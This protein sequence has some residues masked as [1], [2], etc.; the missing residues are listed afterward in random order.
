MNSLRSFLTIGV[1]IGA[2]PNN[3]LDG[4]VIDA[5]PVMAN[6]NWIVSQVNANASSNT[7]V[8]SSS[9]P[10]FVPAGSVGGTGNAITLTPTPAIVAYVAGQRF[11]F[12]ATATNT[13]TTT[14]ATS[15]LTP[16]N[17]RYADGTNL[18]GA[19]MVTGGMYDVQDNGSYYV[20]MN[21]S[22]GGGIVSW[23]PTLGFGG[24]STG[25]TYATQTGFAIKIGRI[26]YM[27]FDLALTSKGAQAG[28]AIVSG[29]PYA[30]NASLP[31]NGS[32]AGPCYTSN[33]TY[34]SGSIMIGYIPGGS[35]MN[36]LNNVTA[37][38]VTALSNTAF[39]NNTE[40]AGSMFF[41]V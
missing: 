20:L 34:A 5:V 18:T 36:F 9:I 29:L 28:Q 2:L 7:V 22:Q 24:S 10:T 3:I 32:N 23:T 17:V 27:A 15:G 13:G 35:T 33:L 16:R 31:V 4:Q 12:S 25:I 8:N 40:V 6:F 38:G 1:I 14:I 21:S 37:T 11:S 19:E 39:A 41:V 30:I 26:V